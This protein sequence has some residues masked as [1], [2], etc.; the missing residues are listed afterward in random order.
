MEKVR[1]NHQNIMNFID[2]W[3]SKNAKIGTNLARDFSKMLVTF[4]GEVV[5]GRKIAKKCSPDSG[6]HFW[7]ASGTT[8]T[9]RS[10]F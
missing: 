2:F 4:L 10:G 6:E 5:L 8:P 9:T 3:G 7:S 1:K